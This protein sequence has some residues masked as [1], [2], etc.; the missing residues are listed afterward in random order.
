MLTWAAQPYTVM[1][2]RMDTKHMAIR[3]TARETHVVAYLD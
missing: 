2:P 1:W 3:H